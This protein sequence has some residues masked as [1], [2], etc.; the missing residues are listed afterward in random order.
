MDKEFPTVRRVFFDRR[1]D[2]RA[3]AE[4]LGA[5]RAKEMKGEK[6]AYDEQLGEE[7]LGILE[8]LEAPTWGS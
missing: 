7:A 6:G 1:R 2:C 3:F 5:A 4:Q 8:A